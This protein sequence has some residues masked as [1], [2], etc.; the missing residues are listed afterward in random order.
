VDNGGA[1]NEIVEEERG[2]TARTERATCAACR[3]RL[4]R[5][6]R[7]FVCAPKRRYEPR[8]FSLPKVAACPARKPARSF[9]LKM[10]VIY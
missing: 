10:N 1:A 9:L 5:P 3:N 4:E 7:N 2:V 8:P 6:F